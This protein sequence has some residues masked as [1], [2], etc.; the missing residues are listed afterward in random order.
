MRRD[1]RLYRPYPRRLESL[2]ICRFYYKGSTFS[3]V[4]KR[5]W[6]LVRPGFEPTN[7]ATSAVIV[8]GLTCNL[9]KLLNFKEKYKRNIFVTECWVPCLS[10]LR[11]RLVVN[12]A[13]LLRIDDFWR[14]WLWTEY[15]GVWS[16]YFRAQLCFYLIT[17]RF[18][19]FQKAREQLN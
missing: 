3:S 1:L 7:W 14:S 5:P 10:I 9:V 11:T 15:S 16:S 17:R 19:F 6:V 13:A 18:F 4:I 2:T 8:N 12:T